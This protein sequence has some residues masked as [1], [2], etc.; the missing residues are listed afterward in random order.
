MLSRRLGRRLCALL[1]AATCAAGFVSGQPGAAAAPV[2]SAPSDTNTDGPRP[3]SGIDTG[4]A[5]VRLSSEPLTTSSK[6][7]RGS[8]AR[9]DFTAAKTKDYRALLAAQRN[10]FKKWLRTSAPKARVTGEYDIALNAVAVHLNGT[11]LSALLAA[12][13]VAAV[14]YQH[15]F[16]KAADDPDLAR[17]KA[18]AGWAAAGVKSSTKPTSWAGYGVKVGIIDSGVDITHPCFA[19][20]GYPAQEQRGDTRFTNNK[21]IVARVF[22]NKLNSNGFTAQA[23]QEHGTHVAGTVACN[24]ETPAI[25]DGVAVPYPVSGVAPGALLGNYN[26]FPGDVDSVRTE[27]LVQAMEAAVADGM[28]VLNVSIGGDAHGAQDLSTTAIDN[29]DRAGVVVAVAAGN[30]GPDEQTIESPGSAERALTAGAATV[31]HYIGVPVR[32]D[33]AVVTV[34]AVGDFPVPSQ[35]PISGTLAVVMNGGALSQA[36]TPG[37]L[38]GAALADKIAVV[39]RGT[40]TF[41]EK[42]ANVEAAGAKAVIVVNNVAGPPIAMG[43]TAGIETSIYAVMAPLSDRA[44]LVEADGADVSIDNT[45]EYTHDPANDDILAGFSSRGPVDVSY[46][47][48]PDVTAPG[49]NVLSSIPTPFCG[50]AQ[51]CWAFFQGTSMATPHLAGMAAVVRQAHPSWTAW[52]VRSAIVN[53][54]NRL[55]VK[56]SA[57]GTRTESNP[58][59]VGSGLADLEAAVTAQVAF[60]R[61]SVSFGLVAG[62]VPKTQTVTVTNLGST[63]VALPGSIDGREGKGAFKL[64]GTA[65]S[66]APGASASLTVTF[67]APK[68]SGA[69]WAHLYVG[70][71]HAVLYGFAG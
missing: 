41:S 53:T 47:V 4:S 14:A 25:V 65:A 3:A 43:T 22:N 69:S 32:T 56:D 62:G 11:P 30:S 19:D 66:L 58:Q 36:C 60:S 16:T 8:S 10:A 2:V 1:A 50:G 55:G 44:A 12:P 52:Q 21:V 39:S 51:Q 37:E 33:A 17:I 5:I 24:L 42:V 28:T 15:V 61:P 26:V 49:V 34:A 57:T 64:T 63:V 6:V 54:A 70:G 29:L 9:V 38:G 20:T 35:T 7:A 71:S 45:R 59:N 40:C 67:T 27:D 31:G 68:Q 13:G 48:K 46:R 23:I 18:L